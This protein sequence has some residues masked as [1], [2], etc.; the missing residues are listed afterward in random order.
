MVRGQG[1]MMVSSQQQ[2]SGN[3]QRPRFR[4]GFNFQSG[5]NCQGPEFGESSFGQQ[6]GHDVEG[7]GL[8]GGGG[9]SGHP[10]Q[11]TVIC[12]AALESQ[13]LDSFQVCLLRVPQKFE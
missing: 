6:Q 1:L 11:I 8:D 10:N 7:K 4:N 5:N 2:G 12:K 3:S 13:T 9:G